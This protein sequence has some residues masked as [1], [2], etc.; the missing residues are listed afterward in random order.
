[1]AKW[2]TTKVVSRAINVPEATLRYWLRNKR[3]PGAMKLP[4]GEYRL[5]LDTYEHLLR[6]PEERVSRGAA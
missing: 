5:P 6:P 1:M 3:V 2:L 4:N